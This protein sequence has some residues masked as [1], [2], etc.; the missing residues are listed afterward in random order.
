MVNLPNEIINLILS[1]REVNPTSKIINESIDLYKKNIHIDN[2]ISHAFFV[3][4][5]NIKFRGYVKLKNIKSIWPESLRFFYEVQ[6]DLKKLTDNNIA[7]DRRI[8]N[9]ENDVN[10]LNGIIDRRIENL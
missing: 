3:Y 4:R 6:R 7:L 8:S 1:F 10:D 9:L 2:Y 5:D